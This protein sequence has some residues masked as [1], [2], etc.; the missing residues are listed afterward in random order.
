MNKSFFSGEIN[1]TKLCQQ[2]LLCEKILYVDHSNLPIK[3]KT[4][5]LKKLSSLLIDATPPEKEYPVLAG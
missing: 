2:V 1:Y 5:K 4:E 3:E